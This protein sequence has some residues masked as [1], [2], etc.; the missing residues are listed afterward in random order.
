MLGSGAPEGAGGSRAVRS[1]ARTCSERWLVS[2]GSSS[3]NSFRSMP[4][5]STTPS[6]VQPQSRGQPGAGAG[7]RRRLSGEPSGKSAAVAA[8]QPRARSPS[9][10]S[11]RPPAGIAPGSAESSG[12]APRGLPRGVRSLLK[13][14]VGP[15]LPPPCPPTLFI[16]CFYIEKRQ[17][18]PEV[19]RGGF[20]MLFVCSCWSGRPREARMDGKEVRWKTGPAARMPLRGCSGALAN[21]G[22]KPPRY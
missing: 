13:P 20:A 7:G 6:W 8:A 11:A 22:T 18:I 10:S 2:S 12:S 15:Q 4:P 1:R 19:Y 5:Q 14:P 3:G 9:A 17:L 16:A 21:R